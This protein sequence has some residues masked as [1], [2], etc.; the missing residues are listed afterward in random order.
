M[1]E[2]LMRQGSALEIPVL[3]GW[4]EEIQISFL[5]ILSTLYLIWLHG[6]DQCAF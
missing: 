5:K 6:V 4:I 1:K 2:K 3:I